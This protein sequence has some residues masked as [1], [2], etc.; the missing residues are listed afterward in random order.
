MMKL[1]FLSAHSSE[2]RVE[3]GCNNIGLYDTP[4]TALDIL[5]YL[6]IPYC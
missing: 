6:L 2:Y 4:S 5:C 1:C 3:P